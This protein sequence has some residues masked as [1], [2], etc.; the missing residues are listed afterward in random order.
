MIQTTNRIDQVFQEKQG[1]ILSVYYTAGFP[2]LK[3]T[4][5]IAQYLEEAGAD[6]IEIGMPFSDPLAD[7]PTIQNSGTQA[8]NNGMTIKK[9]FEQ[10][11]DIRSTVNIPI[12]LMGYMNPVMQFGV[13][14]FCK[15]CQQAG[16]DALIL[17]D[18]PMQEYLEEY[19]ELF[20]SYGLYNIFLISPQTSEERIRLIDENTH[21]FIYM[22]S[23][24]SI[25]G[26]KSG[27]TDEQVTYFKRVQ[28]MQLKHPTLI[29]FGISNHETFS[30][31]CEYSSGAIIGSAFIKV[32]EKSQNLKED[33]AQFVKEVKGTV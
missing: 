25:T 21:G 3:D 15:H 19:K 7:G 11:S 26:A 24:A 17:P 30:K 18:L 13:E 2:A 6:L 20:E 5:R 32:L 28:A 22:V 29:G 9:L 27:I 8:L 31:A 4:A 16:I 10:I 14:N 12:I 33:I 1:K 23:S